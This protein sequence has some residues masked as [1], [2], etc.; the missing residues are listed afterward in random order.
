MELI[1]FGVQT[2]PYNQCC[3]VYLC[4]LSQDMGV[5]EQMDVCKL[6]YHTHNDPEL[7]YLNLRSLHIDFL[8]KFNAMRFFEQFLDLLSLTVPYP[9]AASNQMFSSMLPGQEF[10][11]FVRPLPRSQE[12]CIPFVPQVCYMGLLLRQFKFH[13]VPKI[14]CQDTFQ[15]GAS[16]PPL[17]S[18]SPNHR[19]SDSCTLAL[20]QPIL[21]ASY[22][23]ICACTV[24]AAPKTYD[25]HTNQES[26]R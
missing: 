5:K 16:A 22:R 11:V 25:Q 19:R 4:G 8:T 1:P 15:A 2:I 18:E 3:I 26:L 14:F 17:T 6:L 20:H 23:C 10:S 9:A 7:T 12:K 24:C 13:S 21:V